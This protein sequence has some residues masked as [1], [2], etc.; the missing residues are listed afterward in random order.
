ME[1]YELLVKENAE[2]KSALANAQNTVEAKDKLIDAKQAA[3]DKLQTAMN[4]L[5]ADHQALH[6]SDQAEIER[7]KRD[8]AR[9]IFEARL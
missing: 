3:Y 7:L 8:A 9:T 2:T 6:E 4:K 5:Q 1:N